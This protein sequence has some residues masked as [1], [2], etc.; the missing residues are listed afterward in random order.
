MK[1]TRELK[2]KKVAVLGLSFKPNTD[3]MRDAVSIRVVEELLKL[4]AKVA[5]YDPAA[6]GKCKAYIRQ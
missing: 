4:D 3:D 1:L 5:V 6:Y 2:G